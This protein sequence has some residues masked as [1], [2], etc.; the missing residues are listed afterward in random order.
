MTGCFNSTWTKEQRKEFENNCSQTDTFNNVVFQFRGFDN[1]E[2][3]SIWVKEYNDTILLDSFR[4]FVCPAQSHKERKERFATI[5]RTMNINYKYHFIMPGQ[6]PYELANMKMIMWVQYTMT[7]EGWGCIMGDYTIDGVR[8]E[9]NASPT[10][11]KRDLSD[12]K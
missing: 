10:F 2:F 7:S 9:Q 4:V 3:D 1:N 6:K 5:E 12:T 11:I 8:F